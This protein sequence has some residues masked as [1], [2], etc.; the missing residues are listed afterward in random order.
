MRAL[1]RFNWLG[2]LVF[3]VL[4]L[5][6]EAGARGSPK[7]QLYLP[8]VSQISAALAQAL[9]TGPLAQHFWV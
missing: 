5:F 1:K 7:L 9:M 3:G 2:W 6:W 8:P 4:L